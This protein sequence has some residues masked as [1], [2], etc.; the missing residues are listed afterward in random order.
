MEMGDA[1]DQ[2]G[3]SGKGKG[4]MYEEQEILFEP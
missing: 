1:K 2:K 3:Y 4:K